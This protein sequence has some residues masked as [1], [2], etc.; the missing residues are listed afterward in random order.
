MLKF[1]VCNKS[2]YDLLYK[3]LKADYKERITAKEA[4]NHDFLN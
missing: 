1:E 2:A 4:L 3:L